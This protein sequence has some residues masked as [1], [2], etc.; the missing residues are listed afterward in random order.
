MQLVKIKIWE[1]ME[2]EFGLNKHG[3]IN[4]SPQF[5]L[6]MEKIMP[7]NRII[8]LDK[9]SFYKKYVII[10]E[11]IEKELDPKLHPQYFI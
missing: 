5:H 7:K 1:Q 3:Y 9:N 11:M 2:K 10:E 8:L 4:C 6:K